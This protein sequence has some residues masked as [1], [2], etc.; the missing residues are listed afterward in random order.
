MKYCSSSS[1]TDR[2]RR[3][4]V[5]SRSHSNPLDQT[6]ILSRIISQYVEAFSHIHCGYTHDD[7]SI[8]TMAVAPAHSGYC[9]WGTFVSIKSY[10]S[11][12]DSMLGASDLIP[13]AEVK[14][15]IRTNSGALGAI[16]RHLA[17][18][19]QSKFFFR[20]YWLDASVI[21]TLTS[22]LQLPMM[23]FIGLSCQS[24]MLLANACGC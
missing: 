3:S 24:S 22:Y 5:L 7:P 17:N 4:I 9:P 20:F 1:D 14:G 16:A 19:M 2:A 6:C 23:R 15:V 12:G 10:V 11:F 13:R 21:C 18:M 8:S